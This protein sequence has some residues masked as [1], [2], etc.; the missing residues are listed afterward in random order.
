M[1]LTLPPPPG[2]AWTTIT[3]LDINNSNNLDEAVMV[4][5]VLTEATV[6]MEADIN[7]RNNNNNSME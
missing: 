4:V 6:A 1:A 5:L 7:P 2:R 3:A